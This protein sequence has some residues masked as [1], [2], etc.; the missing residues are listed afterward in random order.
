MLADSVLNNRR[1]SV[2]VKVGSVMIGGGSPVVV[3]SMTNTN[4]ADAESTA[5]QVQELAAAGSELVRI[6]VD[7]EKAASQVAS[8]KEKLE[9]MGCHVPLVGDFHYNGH[10]LLEK[11]P[12]CAE[13]L[14]KYRINP[15]N[16]GFGK[17]KDS[18]FAVMIEKAIQYNKPVR[19]GVN[20]GSLDQKLLT[21]MM[22]DNAVLAEPH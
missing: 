10:T 19:I 11:Y 12:D 14:A 21:Q 6:T 16:V 22:D 9:S 15:G 18:Q 5:R 4:T 1:K 13:A 3:Q 7:T 8:I 17:K 2:G 20:W